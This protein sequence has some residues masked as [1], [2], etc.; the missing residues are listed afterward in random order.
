MNQLSNES[1]IGGRTAREELALP[2]LEERLRVSRRQVETGRVIINKTVDEREVA[3]DEP[4]SR[5]EV[6]VERV[7]IN[8]FVES[9]ASPR[10]E[11]E[12][13]VIP[14]FEEKLVV[15]KRLLLKEE[16]RISRRR[17]TVPNQQS[18]KLRSERVN[19]ERLEAGFYDDQT[20]Q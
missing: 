19:V 20:K 7:P 14:L 1:R 2:V 17:V 12:T 10:Y 4:L 6:T 15:E 8:Q 11:G 16:V 9:P 3:I 18:V 5:D 13:L